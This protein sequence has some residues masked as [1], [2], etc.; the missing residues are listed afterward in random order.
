MEISKFDSQKRNSNRVN[1][2]ID[3]SFFCGISLDVL[4]KF[5]LYVGKILTEI[6]RA[7]V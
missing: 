2:Y 4:T 7:H 5:N 6:G 3:G 1:M